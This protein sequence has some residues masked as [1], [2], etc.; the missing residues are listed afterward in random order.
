MDILIGSQNVSVVNGCGIV[1]CS[2]YGD[3]FSCPYLGCSSFNCSSYGFCDTKG[4]GN[5]C[6]VKA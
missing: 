6:I 5:P 4:G 1:A 3:Y 2:C